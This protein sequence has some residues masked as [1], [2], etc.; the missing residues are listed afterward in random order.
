MSMTGILD[1]LKKEEKSL[2]TQLVAI[3]RAIEAVHLGQAPATA[4]TRVSPKPTPAAAAVPKRKRPVMTD[5]QRQAV[6]ERMRKYWVSRREAK[7]SAS[8]AAPPAEEAAPPVDDVP[9]SAEEAAA[10]LPEEVE[11]VSDAA[12]ETPA[13]G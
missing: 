5:K 9:A 3:Q 8:K 4:P 6:S 13:A 10:P 7:A 11:P 2:N 1:V 12:V